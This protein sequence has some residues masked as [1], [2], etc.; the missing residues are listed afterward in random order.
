MKARHCP[1]CGSD[2]VLIHNSYVANTAAAWV[3]CQHC[4]AKGPN[5]MVLLDEN[6][7][8]GATADAIAGWN[9]GTPTIRQEI[10]RV[11]RYRI[12]LMLPDFMFR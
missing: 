11:I 5:F 8:E 3:S 7:M 12:S 9:D 2:E 1:F 10:A 4:A 6:D